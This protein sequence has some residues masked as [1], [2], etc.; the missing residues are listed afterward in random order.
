MAYELN[1]PKSDAFLSVQAQYN[2]LV[3]SG[4]NKKSLLNITTIK[5]TSKWS[6]YQVHIIQSPV[7]RRATDWNNNPV[8]LL[9]QYAKTLCQINFHTFNIGSQ[10]VVM[11]S[12]CFYGEQ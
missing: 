4:S 3:E 2:F 11:A 6:N 5:L 1:T 9:N 12:S 7:I 8:F 10:I